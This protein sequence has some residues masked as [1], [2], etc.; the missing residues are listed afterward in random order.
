[1]ILV[2]KVARSDSHS[3]AR[4]ISTP[5]VGPH[6]FP[7]LEVHQGSYVLKSLGRLTDHLVVA[8]GCIYREGD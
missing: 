3:E 4:M 6:R 1:V 8:A 5:L 2:C 7:V